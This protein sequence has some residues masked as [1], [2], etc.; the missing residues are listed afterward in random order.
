MSQGVNKVILIGNLGQD[1][2]TR[3][4][5]NGNAVTSCSIATGKT[6]KDKKTGEP[7]ERTEWH[8]VVFLH[9]LAEIAGKY[10]KK[11]NQVYVEGEMHTKQWER[12]GRKQY[13]TEVIASELTILGGGS[14][15]EAVEPVKKATAKKGAGLPKDGDL[16]F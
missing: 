8:R 16:P 7:I 10:L 4:M 14:A 13:S 15:K 6:I 1:P 5:P 11:G 2:E 9:H 12:D 3:F